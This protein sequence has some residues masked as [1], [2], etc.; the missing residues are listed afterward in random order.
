MITKQEKPTIL[1]IKKI[2]QETSQI[3]TFI[4]DYDLGAT[5]GQFIMLWIPRVDQ[6]P[7]SISRQNKNSFELSVMKVGNGTQKLFDMKV[8]DQLG[9][10]GPYGKGFNIKPKSKIILVGGGCGSAPL[11]FLAE[12]AKRKKCQITF[13]TGASTSKDVLFKRALPGSC[14]ISTDDG[15][16][17]HKGFTTDILEEKLSNKKNKFNKIYT[18]GP[19]IMMKKVVDICYKYKVSCEVSLERYMKCGF[20]LCGQCSVDPEGICICQEGPVFSGLR[21]RKIKEFG[22]YFRDKTG[23]KKYY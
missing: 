19:E 18:C 8:G 3:K 9:I 16:E 5:P 21:V 1:K 12:E 14:L 15:S 2:K 23:V 22:N 17:G 11:R 20:G 4:F 7:I 13:I 10:S 6:I